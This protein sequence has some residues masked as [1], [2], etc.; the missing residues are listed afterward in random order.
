MADFN[1]KQPSP[2]TA[3]ST[4]FGPHESDHPDSCQTCEAPK[5][6]SESIANF[7]PGAGISAGGT[8]IH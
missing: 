4:T 5:L 3:A 2:Q 6:A 7:G 8:K 1:T